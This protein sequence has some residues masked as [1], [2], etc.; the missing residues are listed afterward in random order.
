MRVFVWLSYGS[1][2]VFFI[3]T[4][5]QLANLFKT[6]VATVS[7]W[8]IDDEL[9]EIFG[10]IERS[11]NNPNVDMKDVYV[12]AIQKFLKVIDV[13]SNES[14]EFATGF[15]VVKSATKSDYE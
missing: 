13:G 11:K 2:E 12:R 4:E 15:N 7:D 3:D 5:E 10:F 1:A 9:D 8:G 14:F 6:M